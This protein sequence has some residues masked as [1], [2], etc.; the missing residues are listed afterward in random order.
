MPNATHATAHNALL[1]DQQATGA[2]ARG[3]GGWTP[4]R[5]SLVEELG[6]S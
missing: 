2:K 4:T 6:R 3:I 1:L 5:P